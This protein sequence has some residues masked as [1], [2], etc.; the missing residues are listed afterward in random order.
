MP[1]YPMKIRKV[2]KTRDSE[3]SS[4]PADSCFSL[5]CWWAYS[6][7]LTTGWH[8][9][10]VASPILYAQPKRFR[11]GHD[12]L[13]FVQ[14]RFGVKARL[15]ARVG[16]LLQ[17]RSRLCRSLELEKLEPC[18]CTGRNEAPGLSH[19]R[20]PAALQHGKAAPVPR[21][22]TIDDPWFAGEELA[23]AR[24]DSLLRTIGRTAQ[25]LRPPSSV[26]ANRVF[27][28]EGQSHQETTTAPRLTSR[29][30]HNSFHSRQ[31]SN[32]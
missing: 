9:F 18:I 13:V 7:W 11:R 21:E 8:G 29:F 5:T 14:L 23:A 28:Q 22:P 16:E 32:E 1:S 24:I 10:R 17:F 2:A 27:A 3:W 20:V 6:P 19:P 12:C 4:S 15:T 25:T 30:L 26:N 31:F